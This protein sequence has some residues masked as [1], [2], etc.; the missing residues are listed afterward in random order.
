MIVAPGHVP[1]QVESAARRV[2]DRL[3]VL[4]VEAAI[5][6]GEDPC[7]SVVVSEAL[8]EDVDTGVDHTDNHAT[9]VEMERAT[10]HLIGVDIGDALVETGRNVG[11]RLDRLDRG[12]RRQRIQR[13]DRIQPVAT[14]PITVDGLKPSRGVQRRRRRS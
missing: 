3:Y 5:E 1:L 8:V 11:R 9:A 6:D 4:G 13:F 14:S 2:A 10:V 7:L 12:Q